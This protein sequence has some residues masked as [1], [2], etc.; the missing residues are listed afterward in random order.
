MVIVLV[1]L[2]MVRVVYLFVEIVCGPVLS[3][4]CNPVLSC[5]CRGYFKGSNMIVFTLFL[6]AFNIFEIDL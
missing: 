1:A 5:L 3:S 6:F 4:H 2:I